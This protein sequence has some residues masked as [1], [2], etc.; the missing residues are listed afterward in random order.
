[1]RNS[2]FGLLGAA[3]LLSCGQP[4]ERQQPKPSAAPAAFVMARPVQTS[5][6]DHRQPDHVK[7]ACVSCHARNS[8]DPAG[9]EPLRP[10]HAACSSCH[11]KENYL[12]A[13]TSDPLCATCH[14]A[15]GIL[16]ASLKTLLRPFPKQ[17]RQFGVAAFS[18]N[19]HMDAGKM[20]PEPHD[21]GCAFCHSGGAGLTAKGFPAHAQCYSCHVHQADGRFGRCQDC[22]APPGDSLVFDSGTGRATR[23]YNFRHDGHTKYRN[24]S[25]IPCAVCH[26]SMPELAKVSDIARME[27]T[28]GERHMSSCWGTCHIQKEETRC[29][30]CHVN[31][32]PIPVKAG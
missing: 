7:V 11:S 32:V 5:V 20:S 27:P 19:A 15:R 13:S 12:N 10:G 9:V 23:D 14:P 4:P 30:K 21:Y 25:A 16:D 31:G 2:R 1:M 17:L 22:H 29:G 26:G 18:H 24:G 3:L 6:F 8:A 28:R